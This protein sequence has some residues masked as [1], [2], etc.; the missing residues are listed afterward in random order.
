MNTWLKGGALK[1][2]LKS[3]SATLLYKPMRKTSTDVNSVF[4]WSAKCERL[5]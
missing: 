4:C 2:T 3:I 5:F 1:S